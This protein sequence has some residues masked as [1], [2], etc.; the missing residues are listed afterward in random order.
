MRRPSP[1]PEWEGDL[2]EEEEEE[3]GEEEM[4]FRR[5]QGE[6]SEASSEETRQMGRSPYEGILASPPQEKRLSKS[7][8]RRHRWTTGAES[9]AS[10][11]AF[12]LSLHSLWTL[13]IVI[14]QHSGDIGGEEGQGCL[15]FLLAYILLLL[16]LG[17]PIIILE[18][19]LGQYS[20]LPPGRLYRHLSPLLRGLGPALCIQAGVRALMDTAA[21][22]WAGKSLVNVLI[23]QNI[24]N[25][26]PALPSLQSESLP[27]L[28]SLDVYLIASL[29]AVSL[30]VIITSLPGTIIIGKLSLVLLPIA[31]GLL[32]TLVVRSSLLSP[33]PAPESH[34][35]ASLLWGAKGPHWASLASPNLWLDAA[36][37]VILSLQL[38]VGGLSAYASHNRYYHNLVLDSF[39]IMFGHLVWALLSTA[40]VFTLLGMVHSD[41][42]HT[43]TGLQSQIFNVTGEN[44][45]LGLGTLLEKG[46]P[47]LPNSWI[48]ASLFL[49]LIIITGLTTI[50]GCIRAMS[51]SLGSVLPCVPL[52]LT[53]LLVSLFF[54]LLSLV[55]CSD[56]G[57]AIL[58]VI[59]SSIAFW[60][61]LLFCLLSLLASY[62]HGTNY[63]I[64]DIC[65]MSRLRLSHWFSSHLSVILYTVAPALIAGALGR[66]LYSLHLSHL[67]PPLAS[68]SLSLPSPW[69]I[70]LAWSL[71][72]LPLLPL[73]VGLLVHLILA[74]GQGRGKHLRTSFIPSA[75]WYKNEQL[76]L[77]EQKGGSSN[78]V[79]LTRR[80]I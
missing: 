30:L 37:Q 66:T 3:E 78:V 15:P 65:G 77:A 52:P 61:S 13:P 56:G 48:W 19:F 75:R 53:T 28:G 40:L 45:W 47:T 25:T 42:T 57:P 80:P 6:E 54:S 14:L 17:L 5:Q 31:Y 69:G 64:K 10:S 79:D 8:E 71:S 68:F 11:W 39:L 49:I 35:V 33:D 46:F 12:A 38:G 34:A 9:I 44:V 50:L 63:L 74:G 32:V 26:L 2:D 67:S 72:A 27:S 58:H 23:G 59:L 1:P 22:V 76:D 70:P 55:F 60:P 62:C 51:G 7:S 36:A 29:A 18:L 21:L 43:L 24:S 41:A 73:L 20:A 16:L 4:D